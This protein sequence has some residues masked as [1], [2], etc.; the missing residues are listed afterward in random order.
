MPNNKYLYLSSTNASNG[1]D[2]QVNLPENLIIQPYSEI[3]AVSVRVNPNNNLVVI[4]D[5]NNIFYMGVDNWNKTANA[6]PLMLINLD[7]GAY[8]STSGSNPKANLDAQIIKQIKKTFQNLCFVRN[9]QSVTLT[10][11]KL[12]FKMSIM[13]MYGI[14]GAALTAG[15]ISLFPQL[16]TVKGIQRAQATNLGAA[17]DYNNAIFGIEIKSTADEKEYFLS[18]PIVSGLTTY[19]I[20][21]GG[22]SEA[23]APVTAYFEI[24]DP[25]EDNFA[26]FVTMA[27]GK[28]TDLYSSNDEKKIG[29]LSSSNND[30]YNE[31]VANLNAGEIIKMRIT[32]E[33]IELNNLYDNTVTQQID[34]NYTKNNKLKF[35]IQEYENNTHAFVK[36][37]IDQ[38]ADNGATFTNLYS[39]SF[40]KLAKV[41]DSRMISKEEDYD[42][43]KYMLFEFNNTTGSD[44]FVS[45]AF[46]A[47]DINDR[48]GYNRH[49]GAYGSRA[50]RSLNIPN[51]PLSV[52]G[53]SEGDILSD[54]TMILMNAS[55]TNE[56]GETFRDEADPIMFQE[57]LYPNAGLTIGFDEGQQL[58]LASNSF[59]TGV[60][61]ENEVDRRRQMFPQYYL[62]IPT[63]PLGNLSANPLQGQKNT[64]VCPIDLSTAE[65]NENLYTSQLYTMNY[66]QLTNSYPLNINTLKVR[67]CNIDGTVADGI[68]NDTIVCLEIRD[69]PDIK[70]DQMIVALRNIEQN[71][72]PGL[73]TGDFRKDQ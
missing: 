2:F 37:T 60:A 11:N 21:D 71:Y 3:R 55:T 42:I 44:E 19:N 53:D 45:A 13:E 24:T 10:S 61:P 38:S 31:F 54:N 48:N 26:M 66:N 34:I 39:Q 25:F 57:S 18:P 8:L 15:Y 67:I 23:D 28:K 14:P 4:D 56:A 22:N 65:T 70:N 5:T 12:L 9:G 40:K 17:M 1:A 30:E 6:V 62:D 68:L 36:Y 16:G 52:I 32:N 46:A 49:T 33:L 59:G 27:F 35:T 20:E 72:G 29:V 69:N 58:A 43:A 73:Q 41:T 7:E 51:R 64:F 50:A 63:L 47:D